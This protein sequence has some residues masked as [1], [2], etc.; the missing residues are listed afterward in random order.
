M[1][2]IFNFYKTVLERAM[3]LR[4]MVYHYIFLYQEGSRY[5]TVRTLRFRMSEFHYHA[6]DNYPLNRGRNSSWSEIYSQFSLYPTDPLLQPLITRANETHNIT[7]FKEIQS[8][9][10]SRGITLIPEIESPGHAL[11]ITKWKPQLAL[12]NKH[13]LLNLSHPETVPTVKDI[14]AE[15]LPWFETKEVHI[16]ADE[17]DPDLADDYVSFVNEMSKFIFAES[18]K[19][20]RIWGT[21]EPTNN[22]VISKD[23]IIQHWQYGQS[24]AAELVR[25]NYTVINS[26]DRWAYTS[27]KNDHTPIF[28]A[29][30]PQFFNVTRLLNFNDMEGV[31]WDPSLFSSATGGQQLPTG[32]QHN[33]GAIMAAWNDNG[34]DATTQLEA[35]YS[36]REGIAVVGARAWSG[37]KG[38]RLNVETLQESMMVLAGRAPGQNLDR[39]ITGTWDLIDWTRPPG[40]DGEIK[41]GLGSKG[42]NYTLAIDYS[43]A[44]WKMSSPYD[45]IELS[46]S[47]SGVLTFTA[48]GFQYPLRSIDPKDGYDPGHPGRIWTNETS[49]SH[50]I[51]YV[52]ESNGTIVIKTDMIGG[53][54]VWVKGIFMG[55]FEVFIFGGRNTLFSWSQMAFVA[56]L[57]LV[58]GGVERIRLWEGLVDPEV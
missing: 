53:S 32:N 5:L 4:F 49:S 34:P 23:V 12:A 9:C 35:Y 42:M 1:L 22:S 45:C 31:Q 2:I 28:P 7:T 17:Y 33:K 18:G 27:L 57:E 48:D 36:M 26:D 43:S 50:E 44:P 39:R 55:R 8:H 29:T 56:P 24:N 30:Y 11:A 20:V 10:A 46:L 16:G 58:E 51:S 40:E 15:F 52:K 6:S 41:V 3:Y 47:E 21:Y 54:R 37:L 38:L 14:W 25:N 19:R 13:D